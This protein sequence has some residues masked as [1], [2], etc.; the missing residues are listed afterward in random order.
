MWQSQRAVLLG[1]QSARF[2]LLATVVWL[3]V[4]IL[5]LQVDD[6]LGKKKI[7]LRI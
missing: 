5:I 6:Y 1:P 4:S 7:N 3:S 2:M